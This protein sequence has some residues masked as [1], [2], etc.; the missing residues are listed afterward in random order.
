MT[1]TQIFI[2]AIHDVNSVDVFT[3][4]DKAVEHLKNAQLLDVSLLGV[5]FQRFNFENDKWSCEQEYDVYDIISSTES[6]DGDRAMSIIDSDEE[7]CDE[8][9]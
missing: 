9:V 8:N 7:S 3:T 5:T 2:V 6:I 1:T 4:Y